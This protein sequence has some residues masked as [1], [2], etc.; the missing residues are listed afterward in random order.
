MLTVHID[1]K[2]VR[3]VIAYGFGILWRD[4]NSVH[5]NVGIKCV[6]DIDLRIACRRGQEEVL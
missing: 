3:R 1:L 6:V 5:R 2:A 4:R